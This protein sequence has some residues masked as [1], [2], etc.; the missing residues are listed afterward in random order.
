MS[1]RLN[2]DQ[3]SPGAMAGHYLYEPVGPQ[4]LISVVERNLDE[5]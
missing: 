5:R 3:R 4:L 2:L 1:T